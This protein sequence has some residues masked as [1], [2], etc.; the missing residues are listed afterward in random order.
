VDVERLVAGV[1]YPATFQQLRSWFPD[2]DACVEYLARLRWPDG[3]VCPRCDSSESWRTSSGLWLCGSCRHKTSVTAGTIFHRS[4]L[5]L[6]D[7]FTAAWFITSQKNGVSA[8]GLQRVLGFGSY[9]TAW[10]WLHKL[11][12]AMVRPDREQLAG[13]VEVDETFL[14]AREHKGRNVGRSTL[15]KAVVVVAV[16]L[17]ENPQRLG[18]IRL[19]HL[20]TVSADRLCGFVNRVVTPGATVR[21]D[22]WNVYRRLERDGYRH[23]VVNVAHSGDWAHVTLP[24]VHRVAALLKRWMAG[25]LQYGTSDAHLD[26]YLDEFTF[27]FNRRTATKRGLLFYR[28]MQQAVNTDPHPYRELVGGATSELDHYIWG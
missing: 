19:E 16:E 27:R 3:F 21:T 17:L 28:L 20:R 18:R 11:R 10:T 4:R 24:G 14:G 1:D 15:N 25:T 8:L 26:Y 7:W 5:P 9:Q 23:E 2:D 12:R 13:L 22:G 6:T